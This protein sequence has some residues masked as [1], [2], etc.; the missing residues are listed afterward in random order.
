M[1]DS[2]EYAWECVSG[3]SDLLHGPF[4][5]IEEAREDVLDCLDSSIDTTVDI[6]IVEYIKAEE[7]AD[8]VDMDDVLE[9]MNERVWD[10]YHIDE[11]VFDIGGPFQAW[12]REELTQ[13]VRGWV[14]KHV[15]ASGAWRCGDLVERVT[16]PGERCGV[17]R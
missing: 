14:I 11:V 16:Y 1:A 5:S 10:D 12:A 3:S 7:Y 6:K 13:L 4:A 17:S 2:K 9:S 15:C 8:A